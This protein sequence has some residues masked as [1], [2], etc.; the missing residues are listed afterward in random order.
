MRKTQAYSV[1]QDGDYD[2]EDLDVGMLMPNDSPSR[3]VVTISS[4]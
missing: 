3:E 4:R 1:V 2:P